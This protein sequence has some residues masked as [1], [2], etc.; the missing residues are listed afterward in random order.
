VEILPEQREF[1][2]RKACAEVVEM[3]WESFG[4]NVEERRSKDVLPR[5]KSIY[6]LVG[7]KIHCTPH[8]AIPP[9]D[10]RRDV[11]HRSTALITTTRV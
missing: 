11:F 3:E 7:E 1:A 2:A 10:T 8:L 5:V 6:A 4:Q 9:R